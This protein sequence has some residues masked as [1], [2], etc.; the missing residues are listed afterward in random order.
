MIS[1]VLLQE[2]DDAGTQSM[3]CM[4]APQVTRQNLPESLLSPAQRQPQ[5]GLATVSAQ[6]IMITEL[7][8]TK[9]IIFYGWILLGRETV[10][11]TVPETTE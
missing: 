6:Q 4:E 3:D 11:A 8:Q 5:A 7:H 2:D 10:S 9:G 1:A